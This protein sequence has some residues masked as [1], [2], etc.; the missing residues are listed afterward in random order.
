MISQ[1]KSPF[2]GAKTHLPQRSEQLPKPP[3]PKPPGV[4]SVETTWRGAGEES[5]FNVFFLMLYM[6]YI[7]FFFFNKMFIYI[8]YMLPS[9]YLT[10][11]H[12]S[13]GP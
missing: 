9:G 11:C 7:F 3:A 6:F 13:H 1:K 4:A 5:L 10:V 8:Y 2:L 12:G